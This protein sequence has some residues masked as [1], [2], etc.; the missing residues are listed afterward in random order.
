M[1]IQELKARVQFLMN[2]IKK[3]KSNISP[4]G[5]FSICRK[6]GKQMDFADIITLGELMLKIDKNIEI[7]EKMFKEKRE[8]A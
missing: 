2:D 4:E 6:D 3:L 7:L 1:R 5:S 8:E